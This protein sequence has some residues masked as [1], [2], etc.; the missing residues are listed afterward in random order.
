M[1]EIG[2]I[3][4]ENAQISIDFLKV[5]HENENWQQ[6]G[7]QRPGNVNEIRQISTVV[8]SNCCLCKEDGHKRLSHLPVGVKSNVD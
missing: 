4:N 1:K 2:L 6:C 3:V 5:I 7:D 8:G